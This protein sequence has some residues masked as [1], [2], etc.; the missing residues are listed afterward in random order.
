[1]HTRRHSA[2]GRNEWELANT[3]PNDPQPVQVWMGSS[4]TEIE[5]SM[6][7]SKAMRTAL[8]CHQ[9]LC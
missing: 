4:D 9:H 1:M 6:N 3:F 2:T 7:I 5:Y 8:A